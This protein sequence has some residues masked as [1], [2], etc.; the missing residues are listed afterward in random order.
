MGETIYPE[1]NLLGLYQSLADR[2]EGKYPTAAPSSFPHGEEKL[3][4]PAPSTHPLPPKTRRGTEKH[5]GCSQRLKR[6]RP[7]HRAIECYPA[8][9]LTVPLLKPCLP[10]YLLFSTSCPPFNKK[11]QCVLK[12]KK[13]SLKGPEPESDMGGMLELP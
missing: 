8:A 10:R 7:N 9:T 13:H 2:G 6:L 4:T 1:P 11:L 3:P 5:R 12:G